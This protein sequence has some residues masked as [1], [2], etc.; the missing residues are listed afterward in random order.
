MG[1]AGLVAFGRDDENVVGNL[2]RYFFGEGEAGRVNAVVI[3]DENA[4]DL[5]SRDMRA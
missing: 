2:A 4:H 3:G 1:D 5:L